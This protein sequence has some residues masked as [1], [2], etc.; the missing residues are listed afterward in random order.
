VL[1]EAA[2]T[3][4]DFVYED[5]RCAVYVD[6]PA[7]E[8]PHRAERDARTADRLFAI[9]WSVVRFAEADDWAKVLDAHPGTFGRP[10]R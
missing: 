2:G 10:A 5:A 1:V 3:R 9:G 8:Y 6:G 4:P 7:H